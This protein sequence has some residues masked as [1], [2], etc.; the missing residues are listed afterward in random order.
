MERDCYVPANFVVPLGL[1]DVKLALEAA[2]MARLALPLA[3]VVRDHLIHALA[4][5]YQDEDWAVVARV[6]KNSLSA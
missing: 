1:K 5:G 2:E 6:I 4:Q 3:N